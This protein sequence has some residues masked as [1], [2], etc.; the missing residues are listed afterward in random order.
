MAAGYV[1]G[2]HG[3]PWGVARLGFDGYQTISKGELNFEG[4]S[5]VNAERYGWKIGFYGTSPIRKI[6]NYEK[7][8]ASLF[9]KSVSLG[10]KFS[11]NQIF[12]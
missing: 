3:L 1:A 6:L 5:T 7:S 2:S 8:K 4:I 12:H 10:M 11:I 9:Y